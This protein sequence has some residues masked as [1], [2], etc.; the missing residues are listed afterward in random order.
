MVF[1]TQVGGS[2]DTENGLFMDGS[3]WRFPTLNYFPLGSKK[4][5][6]DAYKGT[7]GQ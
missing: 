6:D 1:S 5:S 2:N 3:Y 4:I 7:G